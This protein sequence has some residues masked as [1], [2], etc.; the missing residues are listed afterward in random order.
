MGEQINDPP[1]PWGHDRRPVDIVDRGTMEKVPSVL[2]E[3]A[4]LVHGPRGNDYGPIMEQHDRAAKMWTAIL[5]YDVT[6]EQVILCM[7]ALKVSRLCHKFKRDSLVD[8]AGYAECAAA[9]ISE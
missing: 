9:A 7:I 8:V 3:A 1:A 2:E 4:A 5:G 6:A